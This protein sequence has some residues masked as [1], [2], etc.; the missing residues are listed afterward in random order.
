MR[1]IDPRKHEERRREIL[2]AARRCFARDG[3]R[4]ASISEICAE[5]KI[6]PGHLYHYFESKEA[7]VAAMTEAT[8][9]EAD[10]HL[11]LMAQSDDP[12]GTLV[13]KIESTRA[14]HSDAAHFL[15]FDML[16]EAGH[17]PSIAKILRDHSQ[18]LRSRFAGYLRAGQQ[19]GKI[20]PSLDAD[21]AA[22]VLMSAVEGVKAMRIRDPKL[23]KAGLGEHLT[24]LIGR[25]LTPAQ[26]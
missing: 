2:Q 24:I 17:N 12:I 11:D 8:M 10:T 6:S 23:S 25:F 14:K 3:L 18:A 9:A 4:G 20:D 1:T 7:I 22:A 13:A 21:L 26:K 19:G 15:V 5:A 16:A